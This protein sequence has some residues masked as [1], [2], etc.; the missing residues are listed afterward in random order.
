[1]D[2]KYKKIHNLSVTST[3][4]LY[5]SSYLEDLTGLMEKVASNINDGTYYFFDDNYYL[6]SN[7]LEPN[8]SYKVFIE[9]F[10]KAFLYSSS[11]EIHV[12]RGRAGIGKTLFFEH[13]IQILT[14][15]SKTYNEKYI[16]LGV[17]FTNIDPQK[18]IAFY[19][20]HIYKKLCENSIYAIRQLKDNKINI[21]NKFNKEYNEYCKFEYDTPDEKMFPVMFFC[22]EIHR[23]Y[24]KP[25]IIVLDNVDLASVTTQV[26]IFKATVNVCRKLHEFMRSF[27]AKNKYS[28]FF[29]MRPETYYS[30]VEARLGKTIDF[31][32]PNIQLICIEIIKNVLIDTAIEFDNDCGLKCAVTYY[33]ITNGKK[34]TAETFL[35]VA[36]YFNEIFSHYLINLWDSSDCKERL[37]NNEEF[38]CNIANYNVRKF[39]R[40]LADTLSNGGFEPLTKKFNENQFIS[41]Y[42]VYDYIEMLIRG[43]WEF[44]PGNKDIDGEGGNNAPIVFN[45]FDTAIWNTNKSQQIKH[46]MLFIRILQFFNM[47]TNNEIAIYEEVKNK[48]SFFFEESLI[49]K[50]MQKLVF[51]RIIYS[52]DEGDKNLSSMQHWKDVI[53]KDNT[54]LQLTPT[55]KFYLEKFI[56]EFEY[57]YQMAL[58]SLMPEDYVEELSNCWSTEKELVVLRFLI[59]IFYILK[60]NLENYYKQNVL[61]EFKEIFCQDNKYSCKPYR[62]MLDTFIIVL[63]NKINRARKKGI[64]IL[65]KLV[66]VLSEAEKLQEEST[67]YFNSVV[68]GE[69]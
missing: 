54:K 64:P 5:N 68:G 9:E 37:G 15:D 29:A 28:V 39:L 60:E 20:Q 2:I 65:N 56:C 26:N 55:G 58:S 25:C 34:E 51:V 11:E 19:E 32:L 6:N 61:E 59:G 50:A 47:C 14:R 40:F 42:N 38:H 12:I 45:F 24:R 27:D 43:R 48:L 31:P 44:H 33:N 23:Q 66:G 69:L 49:M 63:K 35:D 67:E 41:Y 3:K 13:G 30:H 4:K 8:N 46:F 57:L 62:R 1:M 7:E 53:I 18:D 17:D 52:F 22:R 36:N 10:R 16:P 21:F